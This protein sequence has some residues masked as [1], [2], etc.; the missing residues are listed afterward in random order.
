MS[1]SN[2]QPWWKAEMRFCGCDTE[3][4]DIGTFPCSAEGAA[5]ECQKKWGFHS[6]ERWEPPHSG[7][8]QVIFKVRFDSDYELCDCTA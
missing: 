4:A 2:G 1:A 7:S 3:S 5:Q 8:G 6:H